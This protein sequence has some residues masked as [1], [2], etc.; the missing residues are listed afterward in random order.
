[1]RLRLRRQPRLTRTAP[2]PAITQ[3][4]CQRH[5]TPLGIKLWWHSIDVHLHPYRPPPRRPHR[6]LRRDARPPPAAP[7]SP[8]QST[9]CLRRRRRHSARIQLQQLQSS[10]Y[11]QI[12]SML[13]LPLSPS[14]QAASPAHSRISPAKSNIFNTKSNICSTKSSPFQ[15]KISIFTCNALISLLTLRSNFLAIFAASPAFSGSVLL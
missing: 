12:F 1:M 13:S 14:L 5:E 10:T 11:C 4:V 9:P 8:S 2:F 7:P 3:A 15:Y 6:S